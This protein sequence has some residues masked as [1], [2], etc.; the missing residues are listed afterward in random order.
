MGVE[1]LDFGFATPKRHFLARN[2]FR[3]KSRR[4]G[5]QSDG[6]VAD[7]A[8]TVT[9]RNFG[10]HQLRGFWRAVG[11]ISPSPIDF[12]R[13]P[14]NTLALQSECVI[15]FPVGYHWKC[16]QDHCACAKSRDPWV[17]GQNNYIFGTPDPNLHIHYT[18]LSLSHHTLARQCESV[19]RRTMKVNGK[20][21]N[22][23]PAPQKRLNWWSPKIVWVTMSVIS[24]TVQNFI[25]IGPHTHF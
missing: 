21:G 3:A 6:V 8:D 16:V 4:N 18:N 11:Q 9:H 2:R 13:R 20:G 5:A 12:H 17:G 24:T 22:L 15:T 23:T 1:T 14:Y 19:V 25:Q 10:D 7:I